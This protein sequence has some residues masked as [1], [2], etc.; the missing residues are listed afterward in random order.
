MIANVLYTVSL[1]TK[2]FRGTQAE[3]LLDEIIRVLIDNVRYT[4]HLNAFQNLIISSHVIRS[5]ER[6]FA[7][8]KLVR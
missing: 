8:E 2:S 6:R 7:D 4:D 1:I 5:S 3:Q